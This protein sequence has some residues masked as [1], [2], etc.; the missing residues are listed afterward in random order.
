MGAFAGQ[1]TEFSNHK[2]DW[3]GFETASNSS[4]ASSI[5]LHVQSRMQP[6]TSHNCLHRRVRASTPSK[7]WPRLSASRLPISDSSGL[8][9]SLSWCR[10][11]RSAKNCE[12]A[13]SRS[14]A[15]VRESWQNHVSLR[16]WSQVLRGCPGA[17]MLKRQNS[18]RHGQHET[19]L[20]ERRSSDTCL[21]PITH[22][23]VGLRCLADRVIH[24]KPILASCCLRV[25]EAGHSRWD[26]A[27]FAEVLILMA[28]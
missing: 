3:H 20:R 21:Q 6:A 25:L 13:L 23:T 17:A 7:N 15:R 28:K 9:A 1:R 2:Q 10:S 19:E 14:A 22:P 11:R 4:S 26:H 24:W 12:T 27:H 5:R 16:V 18:P 8:P